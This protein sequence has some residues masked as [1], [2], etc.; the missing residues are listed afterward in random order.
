MAAD[1]VL[2][3]QMLVLKDES[4]VLK[5][6]KWRVEGFALATRNWGNHENREIAPGPCNRPWD[7][8][9][10]VRLEK[11]PRKYQGRAPE[12][13]CSACQS[14]KRACLAIRV[15]FRQGDG[16]LAR[17]ARIGARYARI[18]ARY[19]R[20]MIG[21]VLGLGLC[22]GLGAQLLSVRLLSAN[23]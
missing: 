18:G 1:V 23:C 20:L 3:K 19:A 21:H 9:S 8:A 12:A 6:A 5:D 11:L 2:T 17:F 4:G 22:L 15:F 16:H 14:H 7:H 10:Q 13:S